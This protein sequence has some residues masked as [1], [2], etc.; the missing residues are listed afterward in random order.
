MLNILDMF[1][2]DELGQLES[3]FSKYINRKNGMDTDLYDL[4]QYTVLIVPRLYLLITVGIVYIKKNISSRR[5][6][7]KDLVEMCCGVQNP[8]RGLFLRNYLLQCTRNVLPDV[9]ES[10]NESEGNV[11]DAIDFVLRNFAE[12]N[13]LWVRMQYQGHSS[14][15]MRREKEREEL[16]ILV[17]TNL[18]RLSQLESA[19]LDIYQR[20]ILPGI[21]EQ[22]VSCRDAIAQ[23]YLME[24][25]IQV[26]PD[27]FHLQT[28]DPFLKSCAQLE[29]GVNVKNI[30]ICLIDRLPAYNQRNGKLNSSDIDTVIPKE[31]KLFEVFS[32]QVANIIQVIGYWTILILCD[33]IVYNS[34]LYEILFVLY[35]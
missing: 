4:V 1:V 31:V 7:L 18:V 15:K 32:M 16:K 11:Y 22:V 34:M 30:I 10:N 29:A 25:I 24:C 28:L 27:E 20:L 35:I 26:F 19:S 2:T 5:Q 3:W 13:K 6:I 33:C 8:L 9:L 23:E 21:L 14:E 17:G 12:M